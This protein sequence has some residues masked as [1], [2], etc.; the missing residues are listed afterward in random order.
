MTKRFLIRRY[1]QSYHPCRFDWDRLLFQEYE[2]V[3]Q[4]NSLS[5]T[6]SDS[7][8]A[9]FNVSAFST[10]YSL[11]SITMFFLNSADHLQPRLIYGS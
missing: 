6:K 2:S 11:I 8:S 10:K 1:S 4:P 7:V 3:A 9:V 5:A